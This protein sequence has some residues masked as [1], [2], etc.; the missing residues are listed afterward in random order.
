MNNMN[1][2]DRLKVALHTPLGLDDVIIIEKTLF[3]Y[4]ISCECYIS[5]F[6]NLGKKEFRRWIKMFVGHDINI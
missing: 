2:A 5:V 4:D 1:Y 6:N 3:G